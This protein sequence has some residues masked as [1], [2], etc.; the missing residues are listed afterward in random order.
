[1]QAAIVS[2]M[3][4]EAPLLNNVADGLEQAA[5]SAESSSPAR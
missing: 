5:V 2:N 3:Q 1:M 4:M